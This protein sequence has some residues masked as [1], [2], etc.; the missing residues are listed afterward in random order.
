MFVLGKHNKSTSASLAMNFRIIAAAKSVSRKLRSSK[1]RH[2]NDTKTDIRAKVARQSALGCV[3]TCAF[4]SLVERELVLSSKI[5]GG[6]RRSAF[7]VT[8]QDGKFAAYD[9]KTRRNTLHEIATRNLDLKLQRLSTEKETLRETSALP[10]V[11]I[12]VYDIYVIVVAH[13]SLSLSLSLSV[14]LYPLQWDNF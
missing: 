4:G 8:E 5:Y 3:S 11:T 9:R 10:I 1:Q 14:K 7:D 6:R 13:L 2:S 12:Q